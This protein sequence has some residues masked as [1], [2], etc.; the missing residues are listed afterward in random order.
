MQ[1]EGFDT[2]ARRVEEWRAKM[3]VKAGYPRE[4]ALSLAADQGVD[5]HVAIGLLE[6]NCELGT[7]LR[8]LAR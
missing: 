5:L 8:I 2:E 4:S 7:A 6:A 1:L 3:L